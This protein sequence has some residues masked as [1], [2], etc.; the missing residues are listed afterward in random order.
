MYLLGTHKFG[1]DWMNILKWNASHST[2]AECEN[3]LFVIYSIDF[4]PGYISYDI[5]NWKAVS[6]MTIMNDLIHYLSNSKWFLSWTTK[7]KGIGSIIRNLCMKDIQN[8][9]GICK[10]VSSLHCV[11]VHPSNSKIF[12][13]FSVHW[14]NA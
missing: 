10:I 2:H 14:V 9:Y 12:S 8:K 4:L 13:E 5:Q 6:D 1:F 7:K 11:T 3:N